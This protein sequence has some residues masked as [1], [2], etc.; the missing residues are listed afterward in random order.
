MVGIGHERK[1]RL[2]PAIARVRAQGGLVEGGPDVGQ[3]AEGCLAG[4]LEA[5]PSQLNALGASASEAPAAS[6]ASGALRLRGRRSWDSASSC[7][8]PKNSQ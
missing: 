8:I 1:S 6:A 7:R 2:Y 3:K 4:A 5:L